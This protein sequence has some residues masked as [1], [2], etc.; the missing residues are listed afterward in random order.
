MNLRTGVCVC[1][2]VGCTPAHWCWCC[3]CIYTH[4][5]ADSSCV[6]VCV[7]EKRAKE[8]MSDES[9]TAV[10]RPLSAYLLFMSEFREEYKVWMYR[11]TSSLG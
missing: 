6:C 2:C 5:C 11:S 10:K 4:V 7:F 1:V 8:R 9:G 3:V